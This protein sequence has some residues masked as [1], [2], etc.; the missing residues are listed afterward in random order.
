MQFI[1]YHLRGTEVTEKTFFIYSL[2]LCVLFAFVQ[3]P[4]R[5]LWLIYIAPSRRDSIF[6]NQL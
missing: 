1:K 2:N 6:V 4:R 5:G 3:H